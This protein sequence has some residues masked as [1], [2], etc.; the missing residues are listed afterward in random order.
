MSV[1]DH[2]KLTV[3][4]I[5]WTDASESLPGL[6]E[7][8]VM[9]FDYRPEGYD[10]PEKIYTVGQIVQDKFLLAIHSTLGVNDL[11][12][13]NGYRLLRWMDVGLGKG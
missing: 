7:R 12:P 11:C 6:R 9:E 10:Y 1:A 13:E 2:V 5:R 3:V 4:D 8:V